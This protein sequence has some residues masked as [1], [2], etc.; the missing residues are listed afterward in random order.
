M[1]TAA[2]RYNF[3]DVEMD[4]KNFI[5]EI[6]KQSKIFGVA[7]LTLDTVTKMGTK[8]VLAN[9]LMRAVQLIDRQHN[10]LINQRVHI[11]SYQ[12]D[13][14]K[15]QSDVINAQDRALRVT[16]RISKTVEDSVHSGMK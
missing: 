5:S 6:F 8:D 3:A 11:S 16:E 13:I 1:P 14:I 7:D 10:M 12:Q 15:L 2:D 9:F 4:G